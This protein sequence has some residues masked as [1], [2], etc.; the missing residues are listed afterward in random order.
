MYG[1]N[2]KSKLVL[3]GEMTLNE[4]IKVITNDLVAINTTLKTAPSKK[5]KSVPLSNLWIFLLLI[6]VSIISYN[7]K[8][9]SI[10]S[11]KSKASKTK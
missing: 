3:E 10:F 6:T 1:A 11:L 2:F 7:E 9:K 5:K 4:T 8:V